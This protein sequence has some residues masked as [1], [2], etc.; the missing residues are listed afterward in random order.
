MSS[1]KL[2]ASKASI[3]AALLI[4]GVQTYLMVLC[5]AYIAMYTPLPHW[6]IG[7]GMTGT[8]F[9]AVLFAADFIVSVLLSFPAAFLLCKLRPRNLPLYL[10][11]AV[12]PGFLWQYQTVLVGG[13]SLQDWLRYLPGAL[14]T[15]FALPVAALVLQKSGASGGSANAFKSR[16]LQC[17]A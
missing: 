17:P 10:A 7:Q 5:W 8:A 13:A 4:G 11:L 6:L 16:P 15:L 1:M 2:N 9:L 14:S 12:V 3:P